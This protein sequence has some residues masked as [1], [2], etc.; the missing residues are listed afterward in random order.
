M[1]IL[2]KVWAKIN[3]SYEAT[4]AGF[5]T[6]ALR[7]LTGAPV[8]FHNHDFVEHIWKQLM[9]ADDKNYIICASAGTHNSSNKEYKDQGLVSDHAYSVISVEEVKHP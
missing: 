8:E 4:I 5:S 9:E 7:I 1:L 3:N 2:E 6:E